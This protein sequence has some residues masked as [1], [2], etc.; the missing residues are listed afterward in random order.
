M[1]SRWLLLQLADAAFPAGGFAHSGGL[2]AAARLGEVAK[3]GELDALVDAS[4]LQAARSSLP[5]VKAA[6][7]DPTRLAQ[8]DAHVD[9]LLLSHVANRSSR[10]QGRAFVATCGRVFDAV[11]AIAAI[12][13]ACRARALRVHLAPAL[14]AVT[15]ALDLSAEDAL[16][17]FL[18]ASLRGVL[19]AAV[20]LNLVG[21]NEAQ[22]MT[23]ARAAL[24]DR[25]LAIG[26]ALEPDDAAQPSPLLEIF[27]ASHDRLDV[28]LF[29][30]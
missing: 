15:R 6:H 27:G 18:H 20:R 17:A 5:F 24:L 22:R 4:V 19:S 2:E 11:S 25:A 16:T 1:A 7:D 8:L 14:G 12:D 30:S 26:A 23:F 9:T 28:R 13:D 3:P 21:P 29:V 10:S